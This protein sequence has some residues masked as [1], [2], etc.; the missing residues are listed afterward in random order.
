MNNL[1]LKF[2]NLS[3]NNISL[4]EQNTFGLLFS[5]T[6]L[7]LSHNKIRSISKFVF[8][9]NQL[10]NFFYFILKSNDLVSFEIKKELNLNLLDLSSNNLERIPYHLTQSKFIINQ[11]VLNSNRIK[12]IGSKTFQLANDI[13]GIYLNDNNLILIQENSF[14]NLFLLTHLDLS[15]N[16]LNSL[17]PSVFKQLLKLEY[18][19]VSSNRL[20][21]IKKGLFKDLVNL[22]NLNLSNNKIKYIEEG[23][24]K[25]MNH[26]KSISLHFNEIEHLFDNQTLIGLNQLKHF[27]ISP[28]VYLDLAVI[29]TIKNSIN[30]RV[31]KKLFESDKRFRFYYDSVSIIIAPNDADYDSKLCYYILYLVQ[32]NIQFNINDDSNT[33]RFL[34]SCKYF[35]LKKAN[36]K[37]S[38]ERLFFVKS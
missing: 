9:H 19:N 13:N 5:L 23:A 1:D 17:A 11:F 29:L 3:N 24:Y 30:I 2:I 37:L 35:E 25:G 34:T 32:N 31:A 33:L 12:E 10:S 7:D 27:Y 22:I 16:M 21:Y 38:S 4:I 18:L 28:K 14:E 26:L 15:K 20:S 36:F 6:S 8:G